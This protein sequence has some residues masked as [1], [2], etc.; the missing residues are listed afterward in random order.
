M[1]G[2]ALCYGMV[3]FL[4]ALIQITLLVLP[5]RAEP[6]RLPGPDGV[7]LEA[8]LF[9]PAGPVRG[10]VVALHGCGGAFAARAAQ[11]TAVLL[12]A[13]QVVLFP[14]SFGSRG[15]GSQCRVKQSERL[16]TS[17][18]LRRRDAIAAGAWLARQE[19]RPV[20]LL[21]WSDGGSTVL[22]VARAGRGLPV[23]V[24]RRFIAFYPGCR[25]AAA[26]AGWVA[27]APVDIL[28]G[29][30]DDWTPIAPCRALAGQAAQVRLH[31]FA[32]AYH[33]FDAPGP[34]RLLRDIPTSQNADRTVRVGMDPAG[35]DAAMVL[36]PR[37]LAE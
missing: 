32:G 6:V 4:A 27:E 17:S 12:E 37:L 16:A 2:G 23:G 1:R 29:A 11:W 14:D 35:R 25:G 36:V 34:I 21:G 20:A 8:A 22:A 5:V 24:F 9:R 7:I 33:D 18:G 28:M 30:A 26:A 31:E 3:S 10:A 19:G 15:L 13:G